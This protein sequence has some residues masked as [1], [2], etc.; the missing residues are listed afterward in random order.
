MC[1]INT[2]L[3]S[4]LVSL[5][6]GVSLAVAATAGSDKITIIHPKPNQTIS[7]VDSTFILGHIPTELI[8]S[9]K[10]LTLTVNGHKVPIHLS[11]GFIAF[12]PVSP[13]EFVFRVELF[14][15]SG[16]QASHRKLQGRAVAEASITVNVPIPLRT[17]S[18][19]SLQILGDYRPP[20]GNISLIVGE[21]L[22]ASF[23]GT[24]DGRAWFSI[25]GVAD[26][27]P[28]TEIS[29]QQQAYW[30]EA[31]FG[32]GAVPDSLKIRGIYSGFYQVS[33]S[34]SAV[35]KPIRYHL[36]RKG[37]KGE[38]GQVTKESN[39]H[40]TMNGA[41]F[42]RCVRFTD[43]VQIVR[44]GPQKGYLSIFQPRGIAALAVGEEGDWYRLR[45]S[46]SQFGWV[47]KNSVELLPL[48]MLSPRSYLKTVRTF[49]TP[50]S[51]TV[52][53]ALSGM[54]P[55]RVVE[56]D[57]RTV[58][59]QIFGVTS[60]TDWIR[61]DFADPLIDIATWSQP[62]EGLY[63]FKLALNS[64]M[65][66]YDCSYRGNVLVFK[67]NKAPKD[68]RSLRNKVVVIDPGH[69]VDPGSIGPT[70]Y[71]EAEANLAIGLVIRDLLK[72]KG[73]RV[74][75]TRDDNRNL[76]L[77]DRPIIANR[78]QADLF[79]SIHNNALPDGVNPFTNSGVSTYYYHPHSIDLAKSIQREMVH[80]TG[81]NDYGLY[82]G[83]LAV[84]RPTQYPA[85][86]VECAFIILPE[87]EAMLKT[88]K[89]RKKV[90]DAVATGIEHFLIGYNNGR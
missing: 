42:P 43:S 40:I 31:L 84:D 32:A 75:M 53:F 22:E 90:A 30:G 71:T 28:M 34:S 57:T 27:I 18:S 70:G 87:Q 81:L 78:A 60:D 85:V 62:E 41:N 45:L 7:A 29:A 16:K 24:P 48:G 88:A 50:D 6:A 54:H 36:A 59:V 25:D 77:Y 14:R 72:S 86:L 37:S 12:L 23:R 17:A 4:F 26:S 56:D 83:N 44:L 15:I 79:V 46:R 69:S 1:S 8:G 38:D 33:C 73:A 39:Y 9:I 61:Y 49:G 82:Y 89:F 13:G 52:E 80:E 5:F 2:L 76:P 55:F 68:I 74:V 63:E 67:L 35:D 47:S 64:D 10:D 65:L 11:G 20:Q 3:R 51:V 21:L 58:R 19:D 66:G